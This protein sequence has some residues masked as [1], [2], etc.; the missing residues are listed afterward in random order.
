[1]PFDKTEKKKQKT[2]LPHAAEIF[3]HNT[4]RKVLAEEKERWRILDRNLPFSCYDMCFYATEIISSGGTILSVICKAAAHF[5]WGWH[6]CYG[7]FSSPQ[8]SVEAKWFGLNWFC[9]L[10]SRFLERWSFSHCHVKMIPCLRAKKI[11]RH[12]K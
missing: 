9:S 5:G 2:N 7:F 3:A 12:A 6:Q 8:A 10:Q 11:R 1:M 4:A